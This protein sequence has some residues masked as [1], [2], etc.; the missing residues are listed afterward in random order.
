[1]KDFFAWYRKTPGGGREAVVHPRQG[2]V[3]LAPETHETIA[4]R[5]PAL[6]ALAA[7]GRLVL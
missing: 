7:A 2:A 4:G 3:V 6:G 1:V 5:E